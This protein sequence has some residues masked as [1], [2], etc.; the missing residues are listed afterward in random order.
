MTNQK[1]IENNFP[2]QEADYSSIQSL[3]RRL[4]RQ[5]AT[6]ARAIAYEAARAVIG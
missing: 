1:I 5:Q 6:Q 2:R 3:F 4:S